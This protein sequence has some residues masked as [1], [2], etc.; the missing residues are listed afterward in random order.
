MVPATSSAATSMRVPRS[1]GTEPRV[2]PTATT[3]ARRPACSHCRASAASATA[4]L[5]GEGWGV[6]M[7]RLSQRRR[8]C[9]TIGAGMA[10]WP[11]GGG[12]APTRRDATLSL[13]VGH[14]QRLAL[15]GDLLDFTAEPAL[16][17]PASPGLRWRPDHWLLI[18]NGR[19]AAVQPDEP[20]ASWPKERHPGRLILPGFIDTHVHSAQIDV[21]GAWGT[22][23]LDWLETHTFP[24]EARMAEPAHARFISGLFLDGLLARPRPPGLRGDAALR[25]HLHR[26]PAGHGR[27][28][29]GRPPGPVHADPRGREP[30]R[31]TL[32]LRALSLV[33]QL[34]GRLRALRPA[35]PAQ[36]AGPRHLA[37][38][39]GP[40][41]PGHH[42]GD[43][44]AL[45]Q[46]QPVPGQRPVRLGGGA[47]RRGRGDPGL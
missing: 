42:R 41:P 15:L 43:A 12:R 16:D 29:D 2:S 45:P 5:A 34:P 19:I 47:R 3:T 13:H 10:R 17:D 39:R 6:D 40:R 18:E 22:E 38:R 23:L 32:G 14:D 4:W 31:G 24:A 37:G 28:P 20:D 30:R 11:R 35:G 7:A 27:G 8:R 36:H 44:V 33:A 25:A 1:R 26:R 9:P 46:L 21:L